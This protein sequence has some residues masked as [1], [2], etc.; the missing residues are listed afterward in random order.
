MGMQYGI[1]ARGHAAHVPE[2][3]P[4][5][6][7]VL[8]DSSDGK[9]ARLYLANHR[10]VAEFDA[11]AEE[12]TSMTRSLMPTIGAEGAEWDQ[13]LGGHSADERRSAE[14]YTLDV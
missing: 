11:G 5:R 3:E 13:A 14:V 12:V 4:A 9:L 7:L 1:E 2:Q 8:I 6:Y 10:E